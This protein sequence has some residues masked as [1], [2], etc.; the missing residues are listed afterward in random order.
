MT[1]DMMLLL[2][3]QSQWLVLVHPLALAPNHCGISFQ[4]ILLN[5]YTGMGPELGLKKKDQKIQRKHTE[6]VLQL[7]LPFAIITDWENFPC[8]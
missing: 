4:C 7:Y 5:C 8:L 2:H 1:L 6:Q 3:A